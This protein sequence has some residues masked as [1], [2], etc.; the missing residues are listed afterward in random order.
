MKGRRLSRRRA[1]RAQMCAPRLHPGCGKRCYRDQSQ[2]PLNEDAASRA[3]ARPTGLRA[4]FAAAARAFQSSCRSSRQKESLPASLRRELAFRTVFDAFFCGDESANSSLAPARVAALSG[5][6]PWTSALTGASGRALQSSVR[7]SRQKR[8]LSM[9][10]RR[11]MAV[12]TVF[13][14]FFFGGDGNSLPGARA[15]ASF[16]RRG[17]RDIAAGGGGIRGLRRFGRVGRRCGRRGRFAAAQWKSR[18]RRTVDRFPDPHHACLGSDGGSR[19]GCFARCMGGHVGGRLRPRGCGG[20]SLGAGRASIRAR[21]AAGVT[22]LGGC[23]L[24]RCGSWSCG[25]LHR[26][27]VRMAKGDDTRNTKRTRDAPEH[28]G[29]R[30]N[31]QLAAQTRGGRKQPELGMEVA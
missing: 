30:R 6:V 31:A 20:V 12:R 25:D 18:D 29:T 26:C 23:R 3:L 17:R 24:G 19:R 28:Q 16:L 22:L 21:V 5:V 7:S 13:C 8:S 9:S 15:D 10:S 11:V 4:S 14:T 27:A 1:G 2:N